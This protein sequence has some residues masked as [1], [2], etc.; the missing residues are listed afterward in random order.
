MNVHKFKFF[1]PY[2]GIYIGYC[3]KKDMNLTYGGWWLYRE[4]FPL[5]REWIYHTTEVYGLPVIAELCTSFH[6]PRIEVDRW[7]S[8]RIPQH[9]HICWLCHM[10]AE[11]EEHY[12]CIDFTTSFARTL[13]H[14]PWLCIPYNKDPWYSS[15]YGSTNIKDPSARESCHEWWLSTNLFK[16]NKGSPT[17][18][19]HHVLTKIHPKKKH[20][21]DGLHESLCTQMVTILFA[22]I[23]LA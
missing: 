22:C 6:S 15:F 21:A 11:I 3:K 5:N 13:D 10:E 18:K 2:D 20:W 4:L 8:L 9:D 12:E 16:K 17:W 7:G 1:R 23:W 14:S 19:V